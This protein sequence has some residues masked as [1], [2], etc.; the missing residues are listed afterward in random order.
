MNPQPTQSRLDMSSSVGTLWNTCGT[1]K[2]LNTCGTTEHMWNRGTTEHWILLDSW[3]ILRAT[4][5]LLVQIKGQI[6]T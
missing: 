4:S 2:P 1:G 5:V 3:V 6:C